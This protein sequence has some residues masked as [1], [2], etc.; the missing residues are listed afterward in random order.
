MTFGIKTEGADKAAKDIEKVSGA[1]KEAD[2]NQKELNSNVGLGTDAMNTFGG[3]AVTAMSGMVA[4][5]RK[6]IGMMTTLRGAVMATGIG[7]LVLAVVAL[8][9]AFTR[10]E[11][12]QNKWAKI[13]AVVGSLINN[14]LDVI[15]DLGGWIIDLAPKVVAFFSDPLQRIKDFGKLLKENLLTRLEGMMELIPALGRAVKLLFQGKFA[16]A[17]KVAV[18]AV[19]KAT[20][21]VKDLTTKVGDAI[22]GTKSL[23]KGYDDLIKKIKGFGVAAQFDAKMAA[24]IADDRAKADKLAR[25][26]LVDRA[27]AD[28][29]IADFRFKAEQREKYSALE[30]LAFL[31]EASALEEEMTDKEI[32]IARLRFEAKKLE[33]SLSKSTKEDKQEQ[34]ELEAALIALETSKLRLQKRLQT[35]I[36]TFRN[37]DKA[38]RETKR[39][40][41]E[42]DA[43]DAQ[44][45]ADK[46]IA[47]RK[48]A[49]QELE[50]G[51]MTEEEKEV[52]AAN[53]KFDKLK[54]I[55][56][57]YEKDT[58]EIAKQR[59][60]AL[61]AI[62]KKH[63]KDSE[64]LDG[65]VAQGRL[66]NAAAG[67]NALMSLNDAFAADTE[68]G[69]REAF[70]KNKKL[71]IASA[72]VNTA[73]AVIGAIAPSAGGL[74]IPAGLPGAAV[75]LATGIAQTAV[76]AKSTF[77]S[78]Q[79]PD[80]VPTDVAPEGSRDL[81][82]AASANPQIDLGFLG[83]GAGGSMQAYV[84]SENVTNQQQADQLVQ[85]Q[86]V[87]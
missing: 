22:E 62:E 69:R 6:A 13:T 43:A 76:I 77:D 79:M 40:Q 17:G 74:G 2:D 52:F 73:S 63:A 71:G 9:Q 42:K 35:S 37:E 29:E 30:R 80:D 44:A 45:K 36:T 5:A 83:E 1:T 67:L 24:K 81:S 18:N 32:R 75:A 41:D 86:T 65:K 49:L 57:K 3:G 20:L 34:A 14:I 78:G 12:G 64:K 15:A 10:S 26:A 48:K 66:D 39:K 85:D 60:A 58:T 11:A 19:G 51:L 47:D 72:I 54:A 25:K 59:T 27:N 70:E 4:G 33:N 56:E 8:G 23:I 46:E 68:E 87:L 61:L 31:E 21:G 7:A 28:R 84:I 38:A 53:K 55:A 50:V 16:E 82:Q